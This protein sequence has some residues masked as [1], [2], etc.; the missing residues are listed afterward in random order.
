M[1]FKDLF[2]TPLQILT[3]KTEGCSKTVEEICGAICN[4]LKENT[5]ALCTGTVRPPEIKEA[6]SVC[7]TEYNSRGDLGALKSSSNFKVK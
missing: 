4:V 2:T 7:L 1:F 6:I 5:S 3:A